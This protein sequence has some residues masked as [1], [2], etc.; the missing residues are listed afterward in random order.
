MKTGK[1]RSKTGR[2][3]VPN[4]SIKSVPSP[5]NIDWESRIAV[6]AY[7]KAEARGFTPGYELNDWVDAE[8]ALVDWMSTEMEE[9]S[10]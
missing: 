3:P 4:A 7:Y 1:T 6:A 9:E 2:N 5:N 8:K 10:C